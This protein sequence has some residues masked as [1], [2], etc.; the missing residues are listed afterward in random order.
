MSITT[1]SYDEALNNFIDFFNADLTEYLR[2]DKHKF[3]SVVVGGYGLKLLLENKYNLENAI[4]SKDLDITISSYKSYYNDEEILNYILKKLVS[5]IRLQPNSKDYKVSIIQGPLFVPILNYTRKAII[6][7][8]YKYNEFVDI[9]ITDAKITK[10]IIDIPTSLKC[11]LPLKTLNEY[12]LELLTIIYRSNV[13]YVSPEVYEKRN[14]VSGYQ[15]QKGI[16][17]IDRAKLICN[18][19]QIVK[20]EKHCMFIKAISKSKLL[21]STPEQRSSFF[22]ALGSLLGLKRRI[23]KNSLTPDKKNSVKVLI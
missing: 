17:D 13:L 14:P 9:A 5:F 10:S 11:G 2:S 20:Y 4:K 19:P 3:R 16:Q 1:P 12:L 18:L 8:S 6:M 22:S 7:V 15:S 23:I 21:T